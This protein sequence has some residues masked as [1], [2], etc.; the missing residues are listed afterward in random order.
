MENPQQNFNQN[1]DAV[2]QSVIVIGKVEEGWVVLRWG[3]MWG[4][5]GAICFVA[6]SFF[7]EEEEIGERRGRSTVK[8]YINY[9]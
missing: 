5:G 3:E 2:K 9:Y 8:S 1:T 7:K 6:K 4:S